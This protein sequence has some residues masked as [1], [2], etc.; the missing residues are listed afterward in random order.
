[1]RLS[2]S[3]YHSFVGID[4]GTNKWLHGFTYWCITSALLQ[5]HFSSSEAV[6]KS[7]VTEIADLQHQLFEERERKQNVEAQNIDLEREI[8]DKQKHLQEQMILRN[9]DQVLTVNVFHN[10]F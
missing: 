3:H 8:Q 2:L 10:L 7:Y 6:V 4:R 5:T 9:A 1:M